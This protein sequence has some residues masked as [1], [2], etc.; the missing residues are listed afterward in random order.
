MIFTPTI[1]PDAWLIEPQRMADER[2]FFARTWCRR[3]FEQRGLETNI[4][5][6]GIAFN[7]HK[8][9]LR[10][11]HFQAAPHEEVKLVR[12]TMGGIF[13]VILDLRPTS[14]T[15]LRHQGFELSAENRRQLYVP[16]GFAHGYLTLSDR[17]E[18]AYQMSQFYHPDAGRGVRWNDPA[19][20]IQWPATVDVINERDAAYPDYKP[21][22]RPAGTTREIKK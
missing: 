9:T 13:D 14:P 22:A 10:G 16:R 11:M 8:G 18:V 20:A 6:C 7:I 2:G 17:A 15:Y 3:D 5:Q 1:F 19:F 12:C 4:A 21:S